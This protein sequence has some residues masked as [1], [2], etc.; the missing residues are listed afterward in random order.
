MYVEKNVLVSFSSALD[1]KVN[2]LETEA[3]KY[4]SEKYCVQTISLG[5]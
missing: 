2:K 5:K 1:E 4:W 3:Q